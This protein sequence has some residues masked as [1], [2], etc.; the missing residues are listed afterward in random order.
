[1][2]DDVNCQIG[3]IGTVCRSAGGRRDHENDYRGKIKMA[4]DGLNDESGLRLA[5]RRML[6][7]ISDPLLV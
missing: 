7:V 2:D 1:V 6:P 4:A 3:N 5:G